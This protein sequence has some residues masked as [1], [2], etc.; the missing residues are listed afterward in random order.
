MWHHQPDGGRKVLLQAL[1]AFTVNLTNED[2]PSK[3]LEQQRSP[4][5]LSPNLVT[6]GSGG[7]S[8]SL[9][10]KDLHSLSELYTEDDLATGCDCETVLR[11]R[12]NPPLTHDI[13]SA[14]VGIRVG[15]PTQLQTWPHSGSGLYFARS[16]ARCSS[17]IASDSSKTR[18]FCSASRAS[19]PRVCQTPS[20][21]APF[22]S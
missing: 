5:E 17:N 1:S 19:R 6:E 4:N 10:F 13:A 9:R 12:P 7:N 3:R 15:V 22:A 14:W 16:V 2:A 20:G 18:R 21:T 11:P 8:L